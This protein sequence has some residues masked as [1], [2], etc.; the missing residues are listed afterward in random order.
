STTTAQ[1]GR[2]YTVPYTGITPSPRHYPTTPT[3][4]D[5]ARHTS[6]TTANSSVTFD[7]TAPTAPVITG[8]STDS[9]SS[10]SDGITSDQTLILS[11]TA[12]ANSTVTVTRVG[13]GIIGT[14]TANGSG[15]WS[16]DDTA[17][18]LAA[19]NHSFTATA[20]DA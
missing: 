19:G 4:T 13:T 6:P 16:F 1:R 5:A 11:G 10:S 18:T 20:T 3:A 7:L 2:A 15:A 14:A 12:E 8:I 17:T 9:G